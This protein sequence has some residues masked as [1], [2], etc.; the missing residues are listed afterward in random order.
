MTLRTKLLCSFA[1]LLVLLLV[2]AGYSWNG[3]DQMNRRAEQRAMIGEALTHLLN[4][5]AAQLRM[6][7]DEKPEYLKEIRENLQE[8]QTHIRSAAASTVNV[9]RRKAMEAGIAG[10]DEFNKRSTT[11]AEDSRSIAE[12][13]K[14]A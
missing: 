2:V 9:E 3:M 4:A 1:S 11:L 13:W 12:T 10:M 8:A 5:Q 7:A 6:V 14:P